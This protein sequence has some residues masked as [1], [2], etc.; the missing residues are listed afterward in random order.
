MRDGFFGLRHHAV[1][2]GDDQNHQVSRLRAAR[3]H[4][5]K[6]LVARCIE[7]GNH[8]L[9]RFDVIRANVLGNPARFTR[10][11]ARFANGI[12]Q[13]G[14]TVIDVTH[15]RNHRRTRLGHGIGM[16]LFLGQI[17]IRIVPFCSNRVVTH[18]AHQ[19]HGGFLIKHLIDGDHRA[20]FHHDLDNLGRF[21]GHFLRQFTDRNGFRD[22]YIANNRLSWCLEIGFLIFVVLLRTRLATTP[23]FAAT[24][25]IAT[26]LN[27][28]A[29]RCVIAPRR[30]RFDNLLDDLFVGH[31]GIFI[32]RFGSRA[33]QRAFTGRRW[34]FFQ[35]H[36]FADA[37][38]I[39]IDLD[40][41]RRDRFCGRCFCGGFFRLRGF[42]CLIYLVG[43]VS[44]GSGF[45]CFFLSGDIFC[46]SRIRRFFGVLSFFFL[47][48]ALG[49]CFGFFFRLFGKQG[50]LAVFFSAAFG[51]F[52]VVNDGLCGCWRLDHHWHIF[53]R[54]CR[55]IHFQEGTFFAHFNLNRARFAGRVRFL[56]LRCLLAH[57][58]DFFLFFLVTVRLLQIREQTR[59]V[60][61][62]KGFFY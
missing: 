23:T 17:R 30:R 14:F 13:R 3:T 43:F 4:G 31:F 25:G 9:R 33:M 60:V 34:I 62:G 52:G 10:C 7:E 5:G 36:T 58:G 29:L 6:R 2:G 18:F 47:A 28:A 24:A 59:L 32:R 26:G 41:R 19:N 27:S 53:H 38:A 1:I 21:N 45:N 39:G 37:R 46:F 22:Q 20:H 44:F 16:L 48:A 55:F 8:A 57:Q 42:C 35:Y 56:N 40:F 15:D 49:R 54:F 12:E 11:H 50:G 61:F 51:D